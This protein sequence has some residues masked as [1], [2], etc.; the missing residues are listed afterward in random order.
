MHLTQELL[1][2]VQCSGGSRSFANET[3]ALK[4]KNSHWK[5]ATTTAI[6]ETDPLTTTQEVAEELNINHS[7]V[8]QH[9]K[10][11]GKV[12]N[13]DKW[14]SHELTASKNNCHFELLSFLVLCNN[15]PFLN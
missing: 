6:T 14:V 4:I 10:Q 7:M 2:N 11:I 1:I 15:I 13:L 5:L 12:K 3:R 8:V 9:L